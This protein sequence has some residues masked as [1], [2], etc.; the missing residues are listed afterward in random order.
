VVWRARRPQSKAILAKSMRKVEGKSLGEDSRFVNVAGGRRESAKVTSARTYFEQEGF[1]AYVDVVPGPL[2]RSTHGSVLT[3][4]PLAVDSSYTHAMGAL[5]E[6]WE[7]SS[8]M[9]CLRTTWSST[10]RVSSPPSGGTTLIV[11][12]VHPLRRPTPGLVACT[13]R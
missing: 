7:I 4:M 8:S 3:H 5:R 2:L 10:W 13:P 6:A 9:R 12:E 11:G 1:G